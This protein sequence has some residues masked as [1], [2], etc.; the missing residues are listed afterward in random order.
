MPYKSYKKRAKSKIE[1]DDVIER[2]YGYLSV[3]S[4]A[5]GDGYAYVNLDNE[6]TIDEF[7]K[8]M[9]EIKAK[10]LFSSP[11]LGAGAKSEGYRIGNIKISGDF[12][13]SSYNDAYKTNSLIIE[14]LNKK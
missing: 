14:V 13:K 2:L 1:I 11:D 9:K 10:E 5:K 6:L 4:I 8:I 12:A 7:K 3:R